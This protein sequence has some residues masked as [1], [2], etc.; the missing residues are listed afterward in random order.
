ME[1]TTEK[2]YSSAIFFWN[3]G[4]ETCTNSE[5]RS[6]ISGVNAYTN[7]NRLRKMKNM[8][9]LKYKKIYRLRIHSYTHLPVYSRH[10][11][12]L[13]LSHQCLDIVLSKAR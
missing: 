6:S 12:N 9:I 11:N 13:S 3:F 1:R 4:Q 5:F 2:S 7:S 10:N 8:L